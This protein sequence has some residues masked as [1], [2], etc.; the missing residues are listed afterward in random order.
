METHVS[1]RETPF[2]LSQLSKLLPGR[3]S[4]ETI[5]RWIV[6]GCLSRTG[7]Q[8]KMEYHKLPSGRAATVVQYEDFINRLQD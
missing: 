6:K 2:P 3:P 4:S 1:T 5:R 7:K 8:I